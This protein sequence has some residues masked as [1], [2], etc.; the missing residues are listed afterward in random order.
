MQGR[1]VLRSSA[2][3]IVNNAD[4]FSENTMSQLQNVFEFSEIV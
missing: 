3:K 4:T 2:E 1:K